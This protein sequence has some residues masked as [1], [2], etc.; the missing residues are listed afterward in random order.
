MDLPLG[1][2]TGLT[3]GLLIGAYFILLRL[4]AEVGIIQA[5][6]QLL[7]KHHNIDGQ[8]DAVRAAREHMAAGKKI[9]A[10]KAYR[11]FTGA[12]LAEAKHAVENLPPA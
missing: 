1:M 6:L 5:R 9:E 7:L 10:I 8:A 4:T 2:V 3:L 12:G 11:Q